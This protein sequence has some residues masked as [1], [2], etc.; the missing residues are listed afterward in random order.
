MAAL[1]AR[2]SLKELFH[3]LDLTVVS[4]K[5]VRWVDDPAEREYRYDVRKRARSRHTYLLHSVADADLSAPDRSL[6]RY[7][8]AA[9]VTAADVDW[10]KELLARRAHDSAHAAAHQ[11]LTPADRHKLGFWSGIRLGIGPAPAAP[12]RSGWDGLHS[13]SPTAAPPGIPLG[14][15]PLVAGDE[16]WAL[17]ADEQSFLDPAWKMADVEHVDNSTATL[18][19]RGSF[20]LAPSKQRITV[21]QGSVGVRFTADHRSALPVAAVSDSE[22]E[23]EVDI[24]EGEM[25]EPDEE[26][27]DPSKHYTGPPLRSTRNEPNPDI[28]FQE[29]N[30]LRRSGP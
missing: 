27:Y 9:A 17:A 21:S 26:P 28:A 14:D 8:G 12:G 7:I 4:A 18:K 2:T 24:S 13:S 6:L 22:D 25:A 29:G 15:E 19:W 1:A 3:T 5:V 30:V 16:V 23:V 10:Y 11:V 20:L